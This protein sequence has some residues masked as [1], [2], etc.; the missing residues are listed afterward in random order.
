MP[1]KEAF[2]IFSVPLC[3]ISIDSMLPGIAK[4][5]VYFLCFDSASIVRKQCTHRLETFVVEN[6]IGKHFLIVNVPNLSI[7][8]KMNVAN[9]SAPSGDV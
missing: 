2:A 9:V 4:H 3:I 5:M 7:Q 8:R 1:P 6:I